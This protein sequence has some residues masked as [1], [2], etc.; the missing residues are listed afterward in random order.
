QSPARR[1]PGGRSDSRPW[2]TP[3]RG[4]RPATAA[5]GRAAGP[6]RWRG[7]ASSGRR[8]LLLPGLLALLEEVGARLGA[9]LRQAEHEAVRQAHVDRRD[10]AREHAVAVVERHRLDQRAARIV[11]RQHDLDAVVEDDVP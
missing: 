4:P 3:R 2:S 1:A 11:L 8:P 9:L 7:T 6:A 5:A 10:L